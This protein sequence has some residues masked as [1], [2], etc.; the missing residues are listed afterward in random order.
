MIEQ[1]ASAQGTVMPIVV[2]LMTVP[3]NIHLA[4]FDLELTTSP[5]AVVKLL[6]SLVAFELEKKSVIDLRRFFFSLAIHA[7]FR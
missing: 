1:E 5:V 3:L 7:P 4:I 2:K 6:L